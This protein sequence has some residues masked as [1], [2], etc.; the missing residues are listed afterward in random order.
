MLGQHVQHASR[1]ARRDVAGKHPARGRGCERRLGLA[2]QSRLV[3][4]PIKEAF[5]VARVI[6]GSAGIP[7]LVED[8]PHEYR[9]LGGKGGCLIHREMVAQRVQ[10]GAQHSIGMV[11]W[12][13]S[14]SSYATRWIFSCCGMRDV[15]CSRCR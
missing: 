14:G 4:D 7:A 12:T 1:L 13:R 15:P 2:G 8:A 6:G 5:E 3:R 10:K 11:A 9:Q